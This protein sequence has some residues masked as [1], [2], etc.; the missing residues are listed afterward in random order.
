MVAKGFEVD[1]GHA[2]LPQIESNAADTAMLVIPLFESAQKTDDQGGAGGH[3]VRGRQI[4]PALGA[5][6]AGEN[7][8][9]QQEAEH[10]PIMPRN[11]FSDI[12]WSTAL[13]WR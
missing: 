4:A 6:V 13:F 1:T 7:S 10:T 5:E 3:G 2:L 12:L 8:Q 9:A 11:R